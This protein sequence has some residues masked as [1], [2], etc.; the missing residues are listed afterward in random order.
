MR[1]IDSIHPSTIIADGSNYKSY[2]ARWKLTCL[3]TKITF[4]ATSE[5]GAFITDY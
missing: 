2:V 5:K 4:H 3:K 1:L